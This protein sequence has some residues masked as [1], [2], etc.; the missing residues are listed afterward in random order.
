MNAAINL[1]QL[2]PIVRYGDTINADSTIPLL[3]QLEE[4][5]LVATWIYAICDN[6]RYDRIKA[7]QAYLKTSRIKLLFLP[8]Y[9]PDV[10]F[11]E[12]LWKFFKK[13]I[14][15]QLLFRDIRRTQSHLLRNSSATRANIRVSC[16][17][18]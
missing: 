6:A 15:I 2:E 16:D 18:R 1:E 5:H 13:Q 3:L 12:R 7:V 17:F 4:R 9:A 8:L 10:N 14:L 11:I